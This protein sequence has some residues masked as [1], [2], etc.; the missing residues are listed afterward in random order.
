MCIFYSF[1]VISII[2]FLQNRS[3][4][5]HANRCRVP[6]LKGT[7]LDMSGWLKKGHCVGRV[8]RAHPLHSGWL[9]LKICLSH[10]WKHPPLN[11]VWNVKR[12]E[13]LASQS[14][15]S[16][17][18]RHRLLLEISTWHDMYLMCTFLSVAHVSLILSSLSLQKSS[19]HFSS[20]EHLPT[21]FGPTPTLGFPA[22]GLFP[23]S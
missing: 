3:F 7:Q 1:P 19:L 23:S 14:T 13:S 16:W 18:P 4:C 17:A 15:L 2:C 11:L 10:L 20:R 8:S 5:S 21:C 9:P 22:Q 12:I 6:V